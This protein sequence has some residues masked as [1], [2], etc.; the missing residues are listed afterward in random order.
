MITMLWLIGVMA[1]AAVIERANEKTGKK[2]TN[3]DCFVV[4]V[5]WPY[6]LVKE[7]MKWK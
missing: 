1:T 6:V 4:L 2:T 7:L 3:L 5:A